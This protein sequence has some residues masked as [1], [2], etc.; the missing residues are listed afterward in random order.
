MRAVLAARVLLLAAALTR[1]STGQIL[2]VVGGG[3]GT[4]GLS[5]NTC[6][7]A[8]LSS[9]LDAIET[10][11]VSGHDGY[12][13]ADDACSHQC[14]VAFE[15]FWDSCGGTLAMM[16]TTG[17]EGMEE[18]YF[19][20]L[21]VLYPPGL[22][23]DECT[24][25]SYQCRMREVSTACCPDADACSGPVP[26]ACPVECAL[27]YPSFLDEC[28]AQLE[29]QVQEEGGGGAGTDVQM[30]E[31]DRFSRSCLKTDLTA[32]IEYA[33]TLQEQ[34][35]TLNLGN[36][37]H[38]LQEEEEEPVP[39]MTGIGLKLATPDSCPWDAIDERMREVNQ[40]CCGDDASACVD[41]QPPPSC[42][43]L[44]AVAFHA[45][46]SDCDGILT[47]LLDEDGPRFA[48]FEHTCTS[49]ASI[50]AV[51]LLDALGRAECC[52]IQNCRG[53]ASSEQCAAIGTDGLS[54]VSLFAHFLR[55]TVIL[56]RQA[57]DKHRGKHL[58]SGSFSCS[59]YG[60]TT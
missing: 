40:V 20:C 38:R 52:T 57:R 12:P 28:R 39:P 17:M 30:S 56:P 48:Q 5:T 2:S 58:K 13:A 1:R 25:E 37:G 60:L 47:Q 16:G 14:G 35:C 29:R 51:S 10:T 36:T 53:C 34:G 7:L 26:D 27:V 19:S 18:F 54:Q 42:S 32:L 44:C 23:G 49:R 8:R 33:Y 50:N 21:E 22:C 15:P 3:A 9:Q 4:Y 59:A 24:D 41:G 45:L 43:P 31:F 11:C 46:W 6:D 55:K